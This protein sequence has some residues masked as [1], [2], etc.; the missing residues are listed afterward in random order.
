MREVSLDPIKR[1]ALPTETYLVYGDT[2]TGKTTFLASFPRVLIF[3]DGTEQGWESIR[4]ISDDQ[5]FEPGVIPKVWAIE[6][7]NDMATAIERAKPLIAAKQVLTIGIDSASFY[8]DLYLNYVIQAQLGAGKAY[9]PRSAYGALGIHLRDLRV[10]IHNLGVNV[11]WL[12]LAK[13]PDED[14]R[15]GRPLIPGQQGAKLCAGV[16]WILHSRIEQVIKAGVIAEKYFELRTEQFRGYI[17]G[18]RIPL[19]AGEDQIPPDPFY[20]NYSDFLTSRGYDVAALRKALPK[21]GRAIVVP[22]VGD[23]PP[24]QASSSGAATAA[25]AKVVATK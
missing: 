7:M 12:A 24:I 20:G 1:N 23:K 11:V 2:R 25:K 9:D 16:N 21:P 4:G 14:D 8:A 10:K 5:L 6:Q 17:A 3:A 15:F 19:G 13:H 22:T 18:M